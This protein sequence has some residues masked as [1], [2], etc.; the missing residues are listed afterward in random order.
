[1]GACLE[2]LDELVLMAP[3]H[4]IG[5]FCTILTLLFEACGQILQLPPKRWI[6]TTK[7]LCDE[8]F[9]EIKK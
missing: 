3:S 9:Q 7:T 2:A 5:I 8:E 6:I 4:F 1:V